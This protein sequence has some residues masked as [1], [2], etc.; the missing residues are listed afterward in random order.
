MSVIHTYVELAGKPVEAGQLYSTVR[1]GHVV[2]SY[3]YNPGYVRRADAYS[4]D[5]TLD[6]SAGTWPVDGELPGAFADSAPDRW[7]R[8]L[9]AAKLRAEA[10]AVGGP[11]PQLDERAFLLGVSDATR[12]GALRFKT[13]VSGPFRGDSVDIPKLIRLPELLRAADVVA[14]HGPD[15]L[16]AVKTLLGAGTG[17]LG[18]ARPKA[19][20]VDGSQLFIAKFPHP[21]DEWEVIRWEKVALDLAKRAGL[22]APDSRLIDV[23]GSAVLLVKRFDREGDRRVGYIS[24]MTL[25]RASDGSRHDYLELAETMPEMVVNAATDLRELWRRIAFS[26]AI[27]NT[28]DHLRNHGFLWGTTGWQLSPLFDVN[29]NPAPGQRM[30]SV[31]GGSGPAEEFKYLCEYAPLFDASDQRDSFVADIADAVATW[32]DIA[33]DN[34]IGSNEIGRFADTFDGGVEL[35]SSRIPGS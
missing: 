19:A 21:G 20:V 14:R 2:S 6:L 31:A 22:N 4:L 8:N 9:I 3:G 23:D 10:A 24:A 27:H 16:A 33:A 7:G 17:S 26:I 32:R 30:T 11:L 1:R 28:D 18:G 25:L 29:P 34:G 5:P 13:D 15:E 12:Q 35:L